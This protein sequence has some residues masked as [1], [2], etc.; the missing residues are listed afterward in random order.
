MGLENQ[1]TFLKH[2]GLDKKFKKRDFPESSE[3]INANKDGFT[4]GYHHHELLKQ[5][6]HQDTLQDQ[7]V[8]DVLLTMSTH[9]HF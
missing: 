6:S 3:L 1:E 8:F 4:W 5:H 7:P 2:Q 9:Q